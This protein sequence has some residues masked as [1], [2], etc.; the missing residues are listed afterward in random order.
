MF[1]SAALNYAMVACGQV[2]LSKTHF[3]FQLC[4]FPRLTQS[5]YRI[6]ISSICIGKLVAGRKYRTDYRPLSPSHTGN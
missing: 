6:A 1:R 4:F 2:R 5:L 3:F